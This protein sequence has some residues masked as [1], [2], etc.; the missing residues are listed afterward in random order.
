MSP[1][2]KVLSEKPERQGSELATLGL[3]VQR[4]I[5]YTTAAPSN[6]SGRNSSGLCVVLLLLVEVVVVVIT[7][8]NTVDRRYFDFDYLE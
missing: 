2:L 7:I 3:A 6:S 4:V 8:A 1:W 5:Y